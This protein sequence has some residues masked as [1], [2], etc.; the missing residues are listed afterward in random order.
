MDSLET[1]FPGNWICFMSPPS[2]KIA[3][4]FSIIELTRVDKDPHQLPLL[5][6]PAVRNHLLSLYREKAAHVWAGVGID[7]VALMTKPPHN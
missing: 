3:K 4:L 6:T 1:L 5:F 2:E 7:M